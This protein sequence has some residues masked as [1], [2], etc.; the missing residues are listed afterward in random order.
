MGTSSLSAE[1]IEQLS[2]YASRISVVLVSR[3]VIGQNVDDDYYQGSL[4]KYQNKGF[5]IT[6]YMDL[7]PIQAHIIL[8]FEMSS[9]SSMFYINF[10][11]F[12]NFFN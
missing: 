5:L 1:I 12:F 8:V 4:Y 2:E 6:K 11:I 3:C 10:L 7:N 9:K